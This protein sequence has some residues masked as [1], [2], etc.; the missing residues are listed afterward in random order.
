MVVDMRPTISVILRL[1]DSQSFAIDCVVDTAFRGALALPSGAVTLLGLRHLYD[2]DA[3][4]ANGATESAPLHLATIDWDNEQTLVTVL[5][6]G[7]RPLVG[8]VLLRD[9]ETCIEFRQGGRVEIRHLISE[10]MQS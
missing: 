2:V 1:P 5:A 8:T 3:N 7:S 10:E 6:I 4:L 9:R